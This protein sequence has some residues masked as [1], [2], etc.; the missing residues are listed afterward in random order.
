MN[1]KWL[2]PL[3]L[4]CCYLPVTAQDSL[5]AT[6]RKIS[7]NGYVKNLASYSIDKLSHQHTLGNLVHNRFNLKWKPSTS[8]TVAA[9]LRNR[10]FWGDQ[11]NHTPGFASRLRNSN[12]AWNLQK[13]W[14]SNNNL[15]LHTNIERLFLAL[16]KEKWSARIGRQRINWGMATVWNPNDIYNAYNFLDI[17]YEERPGSDAIS[18]QRNLTDFSHI[19][20]VYSSSGNQQQIAAARYF[21][22]KWNYDLQFI[23]GMYHGAATLG[24]GWAGS[25]RETGFKG[26]MQYYFAHKDSAAQLNLTLALDHAFKQGW[27]LTLG[28]LYNSRGLN[29]NLTNLAE[30][31][32]SLSSK[33]LMPARFSWLLA[34]RKEI[35]PLS[36]A[37]CTLVYS[38]QLNLLILSPGISYNLSSGLDA[39]LIWQSFFLQYQGSFQGLQ[40]IGYLRLKWSFAR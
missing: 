12:E 21:L 37:T 3:W 19:E 36:A 6:P 39:D 30:L 35:S 20:F 22:N 2:I 8:I 4:C 9:E 24:A 27:Y 33:N 15:V 25:I 14:I 40:D 29:R 13:A 18:L 7:F 17:D 28:G 5:T 1:T 10:L 16:K 26:E 34:G 32:L 31:N 38:P 11:V 23:S